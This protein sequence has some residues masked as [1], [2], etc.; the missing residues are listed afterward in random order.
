ML[1]PDDAITLHVG[2]EQ[3]TAQI[4]NVARVVELGEGGEGLF[5]DPNVFIDGVEEADRQVGNV[6]CAVAKG[7]ERDAELGEPRIEV[8][9][10]RARGDHRLEVLVGRGDHAN[11]GELGGGASDPPHLARLKDAEEAPLDLEGDVA[12]LVEEQ[13]TAVRGLERSVATGIGP[14]EG[15]F[16][17]A[18]EL[19]FHEGVLKAGGIEGDKRTVRLCAVGVQRAGDELLT[20][21]GLS[22]DEDV[23]A[24]QGR[25]PSNQ[26]IDGLHGRAPTDELAEAGGLLWSVGDLG[27][28]IGMAPAFHVHAE[29]QREGADSEHG[30]VAKGM[31]LAGHEALV[32]EPGAV[33][34]EV[35]DLVAGAAESPDLAML[36]AD[37][38]IVERD[39]EVVASPNADAAL[40]AV[41]DGESAAGKGHVETCHTETVPA[42]GRFGQVGRGQGRIGVCGSPGLLRAV[43]P[44]HGAACWSEPPRRDVWCSGTGDLPHLSSMGYVKVDEPCVYARSLLWR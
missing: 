9:A 40:V 36:P 34:G 33:G 11:L 28:G 18:K 23:K 19:G 6:T 35:G 38:I 42:Y 29:Q 16:L 27:G 17:V 14:G 4:A 43:G 2:L 30:A 24:F 21:A 39:L 12:D 15:A 5:G 3:D 7:R 10:K 37:A 8:A 1:T 44:T 32:V 22:L 41:V 13:G 25:D 26:I 31:G 20:G